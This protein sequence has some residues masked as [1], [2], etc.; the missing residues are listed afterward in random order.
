MHR[1]SLETWLS[2]G[3]YTLALSSSFF[4]FYSHCAVATVLYKK[5]FLPSKITGTSAGALVG[6]ALASGIK[7]EDFR[8]VIFSKTL[9]DYWDPKLGLGLLEGKKFLKI[10][11]DHFVSD[12][13]HAK[14]PLEVGALELPSMKTIFLN[15]GSLPQAVFASCA[16]PLMFHPIKIGKRLYTDGGVFNKAGINYDN[17]HERILNIFL[18][19]NGLSSF[20]ER[21]TN[22]NK[23][24]P[25]HRV[26]RFPNPPKVSYKALEQ[27]MMA[28]NEMHRR[29]EQAFERSFQNGILNT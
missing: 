26:L 23:L 11:E 8:D 14:I 10:M 25:H 22:F 9:Q 15:T 4:G 20:Y 18:E 24:K 19:S 12:F 16:V 5:G 29:T 2:E 1:S 13:S 6:G 3:P 28:Y 7:P 21:K 27:G 17:S